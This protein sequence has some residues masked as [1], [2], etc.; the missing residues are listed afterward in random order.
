MN[1]DT[2]RRLEDLP[3]REQIVKAVLRSMGVLQPE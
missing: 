2:P 1:I 3:K